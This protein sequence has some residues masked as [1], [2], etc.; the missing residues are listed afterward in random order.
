MVQVFTLCNHWPGQGFK[1]HARL[2]TFVPWHFLPPYLGA[3]LSQYRLLY[4]FPFPQVLVHVP[5]LPQLDHPPSTK[6]RKVSLRIL[7]PSVQMF[8][9]L[10]KLFMPTCRNWKGIEF[11]LKQN[12]AS[13]LVSGGWIKTQ[14]YYENT[15]SAAQCTIFHQET[16]THFLLLS[17]Y[18]FFTITAQIPARSLANFYRQ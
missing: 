1:L 13:R 7:E 12:G 9:S 15:F 6:N 17:S 16:I 5:Q 3:G 4:C 10:A 18:Y 8:S 14:R 2:L 11:S